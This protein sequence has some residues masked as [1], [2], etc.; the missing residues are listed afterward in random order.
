MKNL[1]KLG[2]QN[3]IKCFVLGIGMISILGISGCSS[4]APEEYTLKEVN[5]ELPDWYMQP[6]NAMGPDYIC[7]VGSDRTR[8]GAIL[9]G[10]ENLMAQIETE[11][12]YK[13]QTRRT[14]TEQAWRTFTEFR[15]EGVL[16]KA[17]IQKYKFGPDNKLYVLVCVDKNDIAWES[18]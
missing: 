17:T 11:V 16:K 1:K 13:A 18:W 2:M 3:I 4:K 14:S 9:E 8:T 10:K 5:A 7:E 12:K 6:K 15:S